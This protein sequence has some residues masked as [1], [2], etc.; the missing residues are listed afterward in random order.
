MKAKVK[1]KAKVKGKHRH[2][3]QG[4]SVLTGNQS[5]RER[6]IAARN[7]EEAMKTQ[8]GNLLVV[9]DEQVVC[10]SCARILGERGFNVETETDP[11]KAL[12]MAEQNDYAVILLDIKMPRIDGFE[13]IK[14]VR[15]KHKDAR[16]V[17]ITGYPS[18]D[19][20]KMAEQLGVA[21]FIPKPFSPD[22]LLEAITKLVPKDLTDTKVAEPEEAVSVAPIAEPVSALTEERRGIHY[23]SEYA[24]LDEAWVRREEHG[25]A[26]VGAFLSSDEA[27]ETTAVQLPRVGDRTYKG[28]PLA[29]FSVSRGMR[30]IV[31]SP[32]TG[33]VIAVNTALADAKAGTWVNPCR[34]GWIACVRSESVD[35][36]LATCGTRKVILAMADE[37]AGERQAKELAELGCASQVA[38]SMGTTLEALNTSS[39]SLVL[40]DAA[41]FDADG[42]QLVAAINERF[43]NA[44]V[45]VVADPDSRWEAEYRALKIFYYAVKPLTD[46]ELLDV[47]DSAFGTTIEPAPEVAPSG[48][49]PDWVS[50]VRITNRHS[51]D[52]NLLVSGEALLA[53]KGVGLQLRKL[54]FEGNY[55]I[56]FTLGAK[57]YDAIEVMQEANRCD[58][59]LFLESR[60]S[61]RVPGSVEITSGCA[62]LKGI[63]GGDERVKTLVIQPKSETSGELVF[64]ARTS[65]AIAEFI[66][67]Q[68]ESN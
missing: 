4:A 34:D 67:G 49:L 48:T 50:K 9:D 57:S 65:K 58:R 43:S 62:T 1:V 53:H 46:A 21:D 26:R 51:Q 42:P 63:G 5:E 68:M 17:M 8:T 64:D 40:L 47:L 2:P 41:S 10:D 54:I 60:D 45:V 29:S 59:M 18:N 22:E 36:D 23:E 15:K 39:S 31:P 13:F 24:F 30:H 37:T 20:V 61:G 33:K 32:I 25:V 12:R 3:L 6:D 52:V 19:N 16:I 27:R 7:R 28:L 11:S 66:L 55:P 35:T 14:E 44:K 56:T 38:V